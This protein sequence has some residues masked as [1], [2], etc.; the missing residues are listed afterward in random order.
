MASQPNTYSGAGLTR[1][2]AVVAIPTAANTSANANYIMKDLKADSAVRVAYEYDQNGL[3][4]AHAA[5]QDF[6]KFS[7][8]VMQLSGTGAPAQMTNFV[9]D[10]G[11]AVGSKTWQILNLQNPQTTEGL[12]SWTFDGTQVIN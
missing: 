7:G 9:G 6:L 4:F 1:G 8:T 11:L 3:P 5:I 12:K 10:L 2:S